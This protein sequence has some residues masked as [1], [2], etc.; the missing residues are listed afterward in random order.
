M[1]LEI[2]RDRFSEE[3]YRRFAERLQV[4]LEVLEEVLARPGF[5]AGPPTIGAELEFFLAGADGRPVPQNRAIVEAARHRLLTIETDRFNLECNT[6]PFPFAG[7]PFLALERELEEALG[8]ARQVAAAHGGRVVAIGILPTF[9]P[10][11]LDP[12]ALSDSPRYRALSAGLRRVRRVPFEMQIDGVESLRVSCDD[13]TYEGANSSWQ[14]HLK[15]PPADFAR[16]YNAAQI[17]IAP[18]LAVSGNSPTFLG[19]Q[20]WEETRIALFRQ[21]VDDRA[22]AHPVDDW[23]PARVSFGHGWARRGAW[24]LLA[25]SVAQHPP[26]IPLVCDEDPRAAARSGA[27]S[28]LELRLHHGCVWHWNRAVYD[29]AGGGHVRIEMR[30]LPAGPSMVDMMANAAFL[31]GL[32]LALAPE[33]DRLLPRLTFGQARRNFYQAARHGLAAELLWPA[34]T[35]PS[36]SPRRAGELALALLPEAQAALCRAGVDAAEAERLL[37]VIAARIGAGQTGAR[38]QVRTLAALSAR[39]SREEALAAMLEHYIARSAEGAPVHQ[40]SVPS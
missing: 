24:E 38:W 1:G 12:A 2:A 40:W 26:L 11:D 29:S 23:R 31:L 21:A 9:R 27:P 30:P 18:V 6:S 39:R 7:R 10:E 25:E 5:G 37:A 20:L 35:P 22:D 15:V 28:L 8:A 13:C 36:P 19:R 4:S 14:I 34:A 3:D 17:A 16:V 32:T 33:V